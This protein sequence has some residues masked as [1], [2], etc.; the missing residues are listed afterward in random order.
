MRF[1]KHTGGVD[2]P[3]ASFTYEQVNDIESKGVEIAA[4]GND[5]EKAHESPAVDLN[6]NRFDAL[7]W[8]TTAKLAIFVFMT[9]V[10]YL[11]WFAYVKPDNL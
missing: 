2:L 8:H 6:S 4:T 11:T 1:K 9:M 5:T 7:S 10:I 3:P